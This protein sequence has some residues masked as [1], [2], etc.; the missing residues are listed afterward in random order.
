[1]NKKAILFS[2]LTFLMFSTLVGA[3]LGYLDYRRE[4]NVLF[5]E[6]L[7]VKKIR[8]LEQN[9]ADVYPTVRDHEFNMTR[10]R[11]HL[12][13]TWHNLTF[14]E[15]YVGGLQSIVDTTF[16][17]FINLNVSLDLN[18]TY[19]I[20]NAT[21]IEDDDRIRFIGL[22]DI[23]EIGLVVRKLESA[24]NF[25]FSVKI[26]NAEVPMLFVVD[27]GNQNITSAEPT[28]FVFEDGAD[29]KAL[30]IDYHEGNFSIDLL[31]AGYNTTGTLLAEADLTLAFNTSS[32]IRLD[33]GNLTVQEL[34][35][36]QRSGSVMLSQG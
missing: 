26:R 23:K 25:T 15:G 6:Q 8:A 13:I 9:I 11:Y 12:N 27:L 18:G 34:F 30:A 19:S 31:P 7:I 16:G 10:F 4:T 24:Y 3:T 28:I 17:D 1:M 22:S 14:D 33:A 2:V 20:H 36:V 5:S 32:V 21:F 35:G 29:I